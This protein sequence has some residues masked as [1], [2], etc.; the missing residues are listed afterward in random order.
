MAKKNVL[1]LGSTGSIGCSTL[2]VIAEHRDKFNIKT[3]VAHSNVMKLVGQTLAYRAENAVIVDAQHAS[4]LS[5]L[6]INTNTKAYAGKQAFLNLMEEKYDIVIA[7]ISGIDGL[8]PLIKVIPNA[9]VVGIANK[10]SI[11]CGGKM[12]MDLAHAHGTIIVPVDSEHSAIFQALEARN[13]SHIEKVTLTA[14]GGPFW[15]KRIEEMAS[16]TPKEAVAHP[17]WSMG[18][19]ISVDSATLMNKGLELIEAHYL[20]NLE[21]EQLD[22]VIHPTSIIHA[23]VSYSDGSTIAQM[24]MPDM[25]TPIA[26]ALSYPER[27][28]ISVPT[29]NL[30]SIG[31]LQFFPPDERRF[32]LLKFAK[33]ALHKGHA[34]CI[35][36]TAANE[37]AVEN[38]LNGVI[39]F[40]D[41]ARAVERALERGPFPK[42]NSLEA[43]M[44]FAQT[45]KHRM[46]KMISN[47]KVSEV[48]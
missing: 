45:I 1:I 42:L 11:I 4:A 24:G 3:L 39:G 26:L 18:A 6:L 30:Q 20:F 23:L 15:R 40:L 46:R 37:V 29:L 9:K 31:Q 17:I 32:P 14:S 5:S 41:I 27:L 36:L 21:P 34:A 25:K 48:L 2:D 7:G 28:R 10:E 8:E 33:Q 16:I 47:I 35:V 13:A 38:F 44:E 19:K 22:V 12:L 43:A